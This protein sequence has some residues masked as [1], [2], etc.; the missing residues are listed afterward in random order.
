[1]KYFVLSLFIFSTCAFSA[2]PALSQ[3]NVHPAFSSLT[4][5]QVRAEFEGYEAKGAQCAKDRARGRRCTAIAFSPEQ[6]LNITVQSVRGVE[7]LT[8]RISISTPRAQI[9]L[10]GYQFGVLGTQRTPADREDSLR[11]LLRGCRELR[12]RLSLRSN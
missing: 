1:M 4:P 7:L 10:I 12:K 6:P 5:E 3:S 2:P 9:R 11:R 8:F